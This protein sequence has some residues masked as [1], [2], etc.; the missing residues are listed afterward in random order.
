MKENKNVLEQI[1]VNTQTAYPQDK[2]IERIS[3]GVSRATRH[4]SLRLG[5][6]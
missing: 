1:Q 4:S 2:P 3:G 6:Q 5:A